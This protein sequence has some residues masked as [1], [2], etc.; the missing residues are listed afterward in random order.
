MFGFV[1]FP[2][3]CVLFNWF[4]TFVIPFLLLYIG[5]TSL[6]FLRWNVGDLF[7]MTLLICAVK[8]TNFNILCFKCFKFS[9]FTAFHRFCMLCFYFHSA[10]SLIWLP[11]CFLLKAL[12][13]LEV[14]F[15]FEFWGVLN[16]IVIYIQ[17]CCQRTYSI[18]F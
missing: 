16:L 11:L 14:C 15:I 3:I 5:L 10:Q 17:F 9:P 4:I 12:Y 2:I 13:C 18:R 7:E 1:N 6:S 8:D